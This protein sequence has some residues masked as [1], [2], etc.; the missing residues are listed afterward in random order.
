[1]IN[2]D[3]REIQI[4]HLLA[5]GKSNS[6]LATHLFGGRDRSHRTSSNIGSSALASGGRHPDEPRPAAFIE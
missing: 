1:M 3:E 4:S 6:D 5:I 2:R